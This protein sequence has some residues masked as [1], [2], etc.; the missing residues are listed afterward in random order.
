MMIYIYI[1]HVYFVYDKI[2]YSI[3]QFNWMRYALRARSLRQRTLMLSSSAGHLGMEAT[4]RSIRSYPPTI[5]VGNSCTHIYIYTYIPVQYYWSVCIEYSYAC[6]ICWE[7]TSTTT[8]VLWCQNI[9]RQHTT[10]YSILE[11]SN[12]KHA[13]VY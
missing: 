2:W 10:S 5:F 8:S 13:G 6:H 7:W 12:S 3:I 1:Q 4:K 9:P 11:N